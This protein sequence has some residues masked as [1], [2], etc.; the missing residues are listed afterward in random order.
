VFRDVAP[1]RPVTEIVGGRVSS[2]GVSNEGRE[3][4]VV[5]W[6]LILWET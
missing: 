1:S 3:P 4:E 5:S 2:S 6:A